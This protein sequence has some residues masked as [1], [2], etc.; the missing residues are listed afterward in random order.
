MSVGGSTSGN[1]LIV[2]WGKWHYC[3]ALLTF[4]SLDRACS[5]G[6]CWTWRARVKSWKIPW[7]L[8]LELTLNFLHVLLAKSSY[9]LSYKLQVWQLRHKGWRNRVLSMEGVAKL[10]CKGLS[11]RRGRIVAICSICSFQLSLISQTTFQFSSFSWIFFSYL[12]SP[13]HS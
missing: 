9:K 3:A 12:F 11:S 7:N 8:I 13:S 1:W 4:S 10:F 2:G 6:S 5:C